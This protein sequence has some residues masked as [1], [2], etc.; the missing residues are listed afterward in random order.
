M[1][2]NFQK[3]LAVYLTFI[4]LFAAYWF[5]DKMQTEIKSPPIK[6]ENGISTDIY[7]LEKGP[8]TPQQLR[9]IK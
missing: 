6:V 2:I 7:I 9:R 3:F 5:I 8:F 4:G 1:N